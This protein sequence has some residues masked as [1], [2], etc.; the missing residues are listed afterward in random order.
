M[1]IARVVDADEIARCAELFDG[2]PL[3]DATERFVA[4]TSHYLLVAYRDDGEAMGMVSGVALTHPDKG[5]EMLLY[6]LGVEPQFRRE[7]VATALVEALADLSRQAG[8]YG[9]WVAVDT[10]NEPALATYRRIPGASVEAGTIVSWDHS[11]SP[12]GP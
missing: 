6:E 3:A 10:D 5:T 9:M 2:T 12:A 4:N 7:G 11:P 8:H 1:R